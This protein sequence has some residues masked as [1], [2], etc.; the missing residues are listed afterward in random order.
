[1][2]KKLR[3]LL[4]IILT[5]ILIAMVSRRA[6][7]VWMTLPFLL[8]ILAGLLTFPDN[9]NLSAFRTISHNRCKSNTLITMTIAVENNGQYIPFLQFHE[10]CSPNIQVT[11]II[12]QRFRGLAFQGKAEM[13][14]TF[15]APKGEF[16]W[17]SIQ[18]SVSDQFSLFEKTLVLPTEA[19]VVVLPDELIEEPIKLKPDYTLMS[20]GLYYSKKPGAG[21]NFFGIREYLMGDPLRSI[22]WRLSARHPNQLFSKEFEREEM[23]DVGIIVDGNSALNVQSGK[24][25][26]F[27]YSIQIAAALAGDIIRKGNRLSLLVLGD[28]ITRVFPGSGKHHLARI[29]N[30][31]AASQ[32]GE[33]VS[34]STINYLPVKLFPSRALLILI[35]PLR[36]NDLP[37]ITRLLARGY[38]VLVVSPDPVKF[39][40]DCSHHPLAVRAAELERKALL[41]KVRKMGVKVID[42]PQDYSNV[43]IAE[44]EVNK[45]INKRTVIT[46]QRNL[47]KFNLGWF[48]SAISILLLCG[49]VSGVFLGLPEEIMIAG[50]ALALVVWETGEINRSRYERKHSSLE[51]LEM[52]Q[53]KLL[54]FTFG[55]SV[56]LALGGLQIHLSIPFGIVAIM[57][58]LLL[59]CLNR[60]YLLLTR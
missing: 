21:V 42:K 44:N 8:Y 29:Q 32:P 14:Y 31:L 50:V 11:N 35:T 43:N 56:P 54:V 22:H 47:R 34:L 58:V 16:Y 4:L 30:Q 57:V 52:V 7:L 23:A 55:I 2:T 38:Q 36:E 9:V 45:S 17:D 59:F 37:A 26:L 15:H 40:R 33:N 27:D 10:S 5:L 39:V 49:S 51:K 13:Q 48:Y 46:K 53:K 28:P 25:Q 20:P 60:F 6:A 3:L 41:W 24:E 18:I 19:E 12:N 1:M